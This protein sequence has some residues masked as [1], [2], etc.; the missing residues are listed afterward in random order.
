MKRVVVVKIFLGIFLIGMCTYGVTKAFIKGETDKEI[1]AFAP[2]KYTDV[3]IKEP[4]GNEYIIDSNGNLNESKSAKFENPDNNTK[5]EYIRAKVIGVV[6]NADGSNAAILPK[7]DVQYSDDSKWEKIGDYYYYKKVVQPGESSSNLF[8]DVKVST[9][10]LSQ[11]KEDQY[12]EVSVIVDSIEST[13]IYEAW[14]I[15]F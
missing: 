8:D 5:P 10:T 6:R 14:G 2:K 11:L 9:D 15:K 12:I 13:K 3:E 4:N 7:L 1:N